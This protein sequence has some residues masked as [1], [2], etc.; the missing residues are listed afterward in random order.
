[1]EKKRKDRKR[2]RP[3]GTRKTGGRQKGTPN[4]VTKETREV[5]ADILQDE[6][7]KIPMYLKKLPEHQRLHVIIRL[8]PYG[9]PRLNAIEFESDLDKLND[10]QLQSI[11][12]KYFDNEKK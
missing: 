12:D 3:K 4:K 7:T 1:M 9:V 8:L 2:G 6:V 5:L 11:I 10:D